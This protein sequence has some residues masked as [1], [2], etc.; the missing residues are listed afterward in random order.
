MITKLDGLYGQPIH[1]VG[2]RLSKSVRI[3]EHYRLVGILEAFNLFN[4]ADYGSY[5]TSITSSSFA[6]PAQNLNLEYQPRM[7]QLAARFEF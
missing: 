1:R 3:K 6:A 5:N 2:M 4:R 7:L